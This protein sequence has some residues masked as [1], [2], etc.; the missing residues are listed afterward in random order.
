M[1]PHTRALIAAVAFVCITGKTV[2]GIYD[3]AQKRDLRVAAQ[4]R[5]DQVRGVDSER[6]AKFGGALPEIYDSGDK[7]FF[8]V[9]HDGATVKG[10]DRHSSGFYSAQVVAGVVQVFDHSLGT[11]FSYD[12]Q[13]A[14]AANAWHREGDITL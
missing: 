8:S 5:G 4:K 13:D 2:A 14:D 7:A 10:Y 12:I 11:W 9:E 3:H 6:D 1:Q